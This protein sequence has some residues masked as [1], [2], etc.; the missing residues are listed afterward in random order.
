VKAGVVVI[1]GRLCG[2]PSVGEGSK[3]VPFVLF[4]VKKT[5][6][7]SELGPCVSQMQLLAAGVENR[8]VVDQPVENER[9]ESGKFGG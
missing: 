8:I 2:C 6:L 9:P 5:P 3:I 7:H 1:A 4:V